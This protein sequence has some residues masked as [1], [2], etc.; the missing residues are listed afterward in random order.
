MP[1]V[2]RERSISFSGVADHNQRLTVGNGEAKFIP[3]V[4]IVRCN[5]RYAGI[6][7]SYAVF[8]CLNEDLDTGVTVNTIVFQPCTV[9][10]WHKDV[11]VPFVVRTFIKRLDHET[12]AQS[13]PP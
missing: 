1:N 13:L 4:W 5:L 12:T 2:E 11:L 3:D 9:D 7:A 6:A 10:S 8:D